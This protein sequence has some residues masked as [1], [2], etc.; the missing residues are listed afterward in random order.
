MRDIIPGRAFD[1][2]KK[3]Q[4]GFIKSRIVRG[5]SNKVEQVMRSAGCDPLTPSAAVAV[6]L[7]DASGKVNA[8]KL[9]LTGSMPNFELSDISNIFPDAPKTASMKFD[10]LN[11]TSLRFMTSQMATRWSPDSEFSWSLM[12]DGLDEDGQSERVAISPKNF[13]KYKVSNIC[14]R[15]M[16]QPISIDKMKI[17]IGIAPVPYE[18]LKKTN[19]FDNIGF[20][21]VEVHTFNVDIFPQED[22][23]TNHGIG[24][25]PYILTQQDPS[26]LPASADIKSAVCDLLASSIMPTSKKSTKR[27]VETVAKAEWSARE[28]SKEWPSPL[29][30]DDDSPTEDV[31]GRNIK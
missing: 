28:S 24:V 18:S 16:A 10:N 6:Y 15:V 23:E 9:V 20:P 12:V 3:M 29:D 11:L 14:M 27:W 4:E 26:V 30:S 7:S 13:P 5:G 31:S 19:D 1:H 25:Q 21:L 8:A 2:N 22:E 17:T